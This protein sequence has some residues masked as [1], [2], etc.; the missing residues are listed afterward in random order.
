M[1]LLTSGVHP[2]GSAATVPCRATICLPVSVRPDR[3][4]DEAVGSCRLGKARGS[5]DRRR[6]RRLGVRT[7]AKKEQRYDRAPVESSLSSG[8]GSL[9]TGHEELA[10]A[11]AEEGGELRSTD[12]DAPRFA[13]SIRADRDQECAFE[14][15]GLT[16]GSKAREKVDIAA[17]AAGDHQ[18][19][20]S[21]GP[22][23][24]CGSILVNA[25][26]PT[27]E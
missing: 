21:P 26:W 6:W 25:L 12:G 7:A 4:G 15:W 3:R 27:L 10:G 24:S 2:A 17:A 1:P 11:V 16:E 23:G 5:S 19:T 9:V 8:S 14:G 20:H 22:S 13:E 18:S